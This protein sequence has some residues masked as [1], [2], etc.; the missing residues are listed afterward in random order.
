L[1]ARK[2]SPMF[3][4]QEGQEEEQGETELVQVLGLGQ[5]QVLVLGLGQEQEQVL[6]LVVV[7]WYCWMLCL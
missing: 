1:E 6:G 2:R 5:E 4:F 7:A 3:E